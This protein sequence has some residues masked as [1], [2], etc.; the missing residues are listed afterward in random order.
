MVLTY[1][2]RQIAAKLEHSANTLID[3]V[4]FHLDAGV[5]LTIVGKIGTGKAMIATSIMALLPENV[6]FRQTEVTFCGSQLTCAKEIKSLLGTQIAY[7]A[8][9]SLVFLNQYPFQLSGSITQRVTITIAACSR[10][11][12]V[13]AGKPTNGLDEQTKIRFIKLLKTLFL[14]VNCT[15]FV[16]SYIILSNKWGAVCFSL[17]FLLGQF[18]K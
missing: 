7:I 10:T 12:L 8:Q 2:T 16:R 18:F 5:T 1:S 9:N 14:D 3:S 11:R 17:T 4:S 15:P 6:I 13:I